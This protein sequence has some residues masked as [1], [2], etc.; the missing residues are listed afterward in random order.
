MVLPAGG[1]RAPL[2]LILTIMAILKGGALHGKVGGLIYYTRN[3][4]SC[5]RA[6]PKPR[7]VP[8]SPA[9]LA[10]R[11][12]MELTT[13]FLTPLGP[14]LDDTFKSADRKKRSGLNNATSHVLREAIAGEY[15]DLYIVPARVLV[16]HGSLAPLHNPLLALGDDQ[17]ITLRWEPPTANPLV[18]N[19]DQVFLLAYNQTRKQ[20]FLSQGAASRGDGQLTLPATPEMLK[21][22]VHLFGFLLGRM[23]QSAS[24]SVFLQ[25]LVDGV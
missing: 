11:L 16:S 22:T 9:Q 10:Q 13:R 2:F 1:Q 6:M 12:K 15:P 25:T 7:A 23:R 8:P 21:G 14:V 4:V 18:D 20:V 24:D 19:N 17:L 5:A 3:G